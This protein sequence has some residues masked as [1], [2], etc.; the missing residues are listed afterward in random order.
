[1]D[2]KCEKCGG[3]LICGELASMHG[4]FFYPEGEIKKFKPKRSLL[5]CWC[6]KD[7][8]AV[9]GFQVRDLAGLNL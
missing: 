6:C 9:Q 5:V 7:C 3:E 2:G 8:G 1:M 4:I